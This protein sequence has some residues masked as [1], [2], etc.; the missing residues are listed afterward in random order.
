MYDDRK[1]FH[2]LVMN[3]YLCWFS[4]FYLSGLK[5]TNFQRR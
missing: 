1:I 3:K 5:E 2:I 4:D